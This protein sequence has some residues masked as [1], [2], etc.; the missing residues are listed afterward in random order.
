MTVSNFLFMPQD[1]AGRSLGC[2]QLLSPPQWHFHYSF[3]NS[4]SISALTLYQMSHLVSASRHCWN[5]SCM[6]PVTGLQ[7]SELSTLSPKPGVSTWHWRKLYVLVFIIYRTY[8]LMFDH[9]KYPKQKMYLF[10][11]TYKVHFFSDWELC[12]N[13]FL[14]GSYYVTPLKTSDRFRYFFEREKNAIYF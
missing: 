11:V 13:I 2:G 3:L 8:I 7:Q 12:P 1:S 10:L 6:Y 9:R 14:K 4:L 5:V